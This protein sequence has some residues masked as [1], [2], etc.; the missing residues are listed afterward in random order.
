M[1]NKVELCLEVVEVPLL[2]R[3][4]EDYSRE[5]VAEMTLLALPRTAFFFFLVQGHHCS[6]QE[7]DLCK[8]ITPSNG[9]ITISVVAKT[10]S[11]EW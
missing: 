10:V 2:A 11:L 3:S 7:D 5:R 4:V 6:T 9:A 1:V 8:M